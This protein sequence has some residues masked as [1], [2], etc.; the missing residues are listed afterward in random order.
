[1][2]LYYAWLQVLLRLSPGHSRRYSIRLP[3]IEGQIPA[4]ADT[5]LLF[6]AAADSRYFDKYGRSFIGSLLA[7]QSALGVHMHL[8]NP[9]PEQLDYLQRLAGGDTGLRLS[10]TWEQVDL[11]PLPKPRQGRYYYS[12]RFVR[13]AQV[14]YQSGADC[15]C[16]DIDTLLVRPVTEL[17]TVLKECDIAFY[18]R[19]RRFGIDTKLLAGTLFVRQAPLPLQLLTNIADKISRFISGGQ[20]LNKLDQI[21]I[22][23]EFKR[24]IKHKPGLRFKPLDETVIDTRFTA[25]GI[26]WYPKGQSKNDALYD[27][28]RRQYS[29]RLE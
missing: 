7:H 11:R 18:P 21:V 6:F 23:D 26:V 15:L 29:A 5:P 14:M 27:E 1:M 28:K 12:M 13:M 10:Y 8:F 16:L 19:F 9:E 24:F 22:Y 3:A 2:Y 25:T 4:R 17:V 20:V